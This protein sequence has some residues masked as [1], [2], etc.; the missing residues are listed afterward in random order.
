M[1]NNDSNK[2]EDNANRDN[3]AAL[4]NARSCAEREANRRRAE[5]LAACRRAVSCLERFAADARREVERAADRDPT[6]LVALPVELLS[7]SEA[8]ATNA[9]AELRR[10]LL[11][12]AEYMNALGVS[13]GMTRGR[14]S[15]R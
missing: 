14:H 7:L 9:G 6:R 5:V 11:D 4:D 10:A 13:E 3:H 12:A 8:G 2:P 1:T 15:G